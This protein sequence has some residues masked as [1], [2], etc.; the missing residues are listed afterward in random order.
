MVDLVDRARAA[1]TERAELP[2]MSL[3]EHLAELRRRIVHTAL[4]LIAGFFAAWGFHER[5]YGF[6][7]KPIVVCAGQTPHA[8]AAR[9]SQPH[10]PLQHVP[11][12]Q[13]HGGLHPR[14]PVRALRIVALHLAGALS[15]RKTL[16]RAVHVSDHRPVP[17]RRLFRIPLGLSPARSIFSSDSTRNSAP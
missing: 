7:Q 14:L 3:L 17:R 9:L 13:L 8:N 12:D 1:V 6:M 10:R 2:G 4:Y 5:I 16:D 15:E 11:E